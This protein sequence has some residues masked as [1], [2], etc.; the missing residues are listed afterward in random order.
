TFTT[1]HP[2]GQPR[3][4]NIHR[5]AQAVDRAVIAPG[6]DFSLNGIA[7]ERTKAKGY[8]EAPFIAGNKIEPSIGGG[9]SQFSTTMYN[10]AYFAGLPILVSQPHSL[11]ID[12]YPAGRETTLNWPTIDLQWRNDTGAPILVRTSYTETSVT[13][14]LYGHNGG[15]RVQAIP[16]DRQPNPG[17]NFTI[18]VTRVVRYPDGRVTRTPRTTSYANEVT[19][20]A[21]QE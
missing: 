16:G 21:P 18:T 20:G 13:V 5:I 9:V 3:V 2:A 12:R 15:R 4:T 7:G 8:V 6:E 17:G 14:T 1:Y 19:D 11:F 10:A